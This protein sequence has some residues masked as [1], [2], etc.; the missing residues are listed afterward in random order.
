MTGL[1]ALD[2]PIRRLTE[3]DL[4]ACIELTV[5]RGWL[6]EEPKWRLMFAVSELYGV[7]DPA[8]G[9]AGVVGLTR[10][11][12]RLASVGMMLVAARHGR[13]GIGRRLMRHVL[14]QAGTATVCLY[15]TAMGRPLYE[16]LGF[17]TIDLAIRYTGTLLP[18]ER[19]GASAAGRL[20]VLSAADVEQIAEMDAHA[21]GGSRRALLAGI[22]SIAD[23]FVLCD[24]P[25]SGYGMVWPNGEFRVIGPVVASSEAVVPG[26]LD[27][28]LA[29]SP[30][31]VRID[32]SS[33]HGLLAAW[34][35][36]RGLTAASQTAI[37]AYGGTPP[38]DR[39][40]LYA[41]ANVALG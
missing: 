10:Y 22:A 23:S 6:P 1:L 16:Q 37:M 39:S 17:E 9:L 13:Q 28:L 3:R 4:A 26:L 34:A 5:D 15:A 33:R 8:G 30:W 29:G 2:L 21:F 40:W 36:A 19:E 32:V 20:R 18:A 7:D 27:G 38:G 41:P 24:N 12:P 11:G 31:P 35:K 14:E 25:A